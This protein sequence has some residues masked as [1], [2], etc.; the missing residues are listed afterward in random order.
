M[1]RGRGRDNTSLVLCFCHIVEIAVLFD[2]IDP[3]TGQH[4]LAVYSILTIHPFYGLARL[5]RRF[6][7]AVAPRAGQSVRGLVTRKDAGRVGSSISEHVPIFM[8][9]SA[10]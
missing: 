8:C 1:R 6:R 3:P 4:G 7:P 10:L 9:P 5:D 2:L